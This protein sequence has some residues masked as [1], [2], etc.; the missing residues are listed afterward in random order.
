MLRVHLRTSPEQWRHE[1]HAVKLLQNS[2]EHCPNENDAHQR[3][4]EGKGDLSKTAT[5]NNCC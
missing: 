1:D 2:F 4:V 5:S 3:L